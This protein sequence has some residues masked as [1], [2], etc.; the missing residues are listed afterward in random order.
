MCCVFV[1]FLCVRYFRFCVFFSCFS[2]PEFSRFCLLWNKI[3]MHIR[4]ITPPSGGRVKGPSTRDCSS[5]VI[6]GLP[7]TP[8]VSLSRPS[9]GS[10][11]GWVSQRYVPIAYPHVFTRTL[12]IL[13]HASL[14]FLSH[15]R[16]LSPT[17]FIPSFCNCRF[18]FIFLG[19]RL[20][21]TVL[22]VINQI[23]TPYIYSGRR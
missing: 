13:L 9:S 2:S 12:P 11:L 6:F 3:I 20:M 14:Y 23:N 1:L 19:V 5:R 4:I 8:V 15:W 18:L 16:G 7:R 21:V 10:G 22:I 17:G